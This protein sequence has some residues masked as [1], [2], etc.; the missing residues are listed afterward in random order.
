MADKKQEETAAVATD[1]SEISVRSPK[2]QRS[3]TL[4]RNFGATLAE[5]VDM[6]GEE[7]VFGIYHRQVKIACQQRVRSALDAKN[8]DGSLKYTEDEAIQAGL[9]FDPTVVRKGG[10]PRKDPLEKLKEDVKNGKRSKED[11]RAA[12][13]AMLADL[14]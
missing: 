12:I 7:C 4:S 8:E 14:D 9:E 10:G 1:P 11:L 5:A 13:E 2:T 6:F 3:V